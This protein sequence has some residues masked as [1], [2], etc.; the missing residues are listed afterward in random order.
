MNSLVRKKILVTK[1]QQD[2]EFSLRLLIEAGAEIIYFPTIKV[3]P[4]DDSPLLNETL[5][6]FDDFDFVVFT[7]ANA[8]E[9]FAKITKRNH[10]DL[11]GVKVAA[12]GKSSE[13]KCE[14]VGISVDILPDE[15]S[16]K[17][18]INKFS[19]FDLTGKKFFIPCSSLSRDELSLGLAELGGE[20]FSVP[21]Y[22]VVQNNLSGLKNEYAL[23]QEKRPDVFVFTSPSSF[24][25]FLKLMS[26]T[27]IDSYFGAN[28]ICAIGSTTERAIRNEGLVVNIVPKSFSLQGVAEAIIKYFQVTDNIA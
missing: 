8:V 18:L 3:L 5:K 7:S 1:S 17:G 9:V 23:I 22:D 6:M 21:V 4:V 14:S 27:N 16:T 20:V 11:S 2:A 12:V 26:V 24:Q 15:F 10:L 25:S 13:E 28:I 19:G